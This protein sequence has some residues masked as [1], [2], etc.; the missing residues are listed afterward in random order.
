MD[1]A[2]P[3]VTF[4]HRMGHDISNLN[5]AEIGKLLAAGGYQTGFHNLRAVVRRPQTGRRYLRPDLRRAIQQGRLGLQTLAV[6]HH[7]GFTG[8]NLRG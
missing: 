5:G 7:R 2:D 1:A 6:Q 8:F 4:L 3:D